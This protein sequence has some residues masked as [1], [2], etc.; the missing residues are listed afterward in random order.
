MG[1]ICNMLCTF[2]PRRRNYWLEHSFVTK[3][4]Y[5][6]HV[7]SSTVLSLPNPLYMS[8]ILQLPNPNSRLVGHGFKLNLN[9]YFDK[10]LHKY[11]HLKCLFHGPNWLSVIWTS[12]PTTA[13]PWRALAN[14]TTFCTCVLQIKQSA[15]PI[16]YSLLIRYL[17]V[18]I[19]S[20]E[21]KL[22][23]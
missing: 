9:I 3:F 22:S 1:D 10:S 8:I 15:H 21:S 13:L 23:H 6:H 2:V 19:T 12:G 14:C 11:G 16:S 18:A 7:V 4:V 17:P 5:Y 20:Q